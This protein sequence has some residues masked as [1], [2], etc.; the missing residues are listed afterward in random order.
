MG[1]NKRINDDDVLLILKLHGRGTPPPKIADV[2][3]VS[4]HTVRRCIQF[5][6]FFKE[7]EG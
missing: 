5:Y 4:T 1:R 2:L 7:I 3:G 6:K